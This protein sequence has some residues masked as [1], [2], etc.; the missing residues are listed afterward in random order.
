MNSTAFQMIMFSSI[1]NVQMAGA[2]AASGES[3]QEASLAKAR[4]ADF[5]QCICENMATAC[6]AVTAAGFA[7]TDTP[8]TAL[9]VERKNK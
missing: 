2:T 7:S 1:G 9:I 3:V 4:T 5:M 6:M 8:E